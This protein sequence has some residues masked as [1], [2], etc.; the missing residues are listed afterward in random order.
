[1]TIKEIAQLCG[2]SRGTVDRVLNGRGRVKPETEQLILRK[3]EELGYTKNVAGRALTIK[4]IA[5]KIGVVMA[6]EGNPFFGDVLQGVSRAE[7][8]LAEY[9]VTV[10]RRGMRGYSVI[11][12]LAL[13]D[14]LEENGMSVLVLQAINDERIRQRIR[15]LRER[16]IPTITVNTDIERSERVSYVGSDYLLGGKTAAGLMGLATS[17]CGSVGV[18]TGVDTLLGHV[19]RLYGF[20]R[21]LAERY[22]DV[23]IVDR[24]CGMDDAEVSYEVTDYMLRRHPE[25]DAIMIIAAGAEGVCRAVHDRG[26]EKRIRIVAFDAVPAV[27]ERMKM[28]LIR[29]VVCQ[30]PQMQGYRAVRAAFECLLGPERVQDAQIMENQIK[31]VENL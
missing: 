15:Q 14:E 19:Q 20:E 7:Q 4:R 28:G 3:I 5:P 29:A 9:G 6:S 22:P 31:I 12:Q 8:E 21:H 25:I 30:Q 13:I 11:T 1:M 27:I 24:V 23:Q 10:T 2:V 18:V 26:E 16:G 17:G